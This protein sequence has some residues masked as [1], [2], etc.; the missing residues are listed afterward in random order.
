MTAQSAAQSAHK[1]HQSACSGWVGLSPLGD[2]PPEL[3]GQSTTLCTLCRPENTEK[4][5]PF[6]ST[7]AQSGL[8]KVLHKVVGEHFVHFVQTTVRASGSERQ[9]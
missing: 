3:D 8:H 4:N 7:S 9:R 2:T 1:V 6:R 5:R